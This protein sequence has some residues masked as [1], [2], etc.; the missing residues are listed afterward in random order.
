LGVKGLVVIENS[1]DPLHDGEHL[2]HFR[3][4]SECGWLGRLRDMSVE[5]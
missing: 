2:T 4:R 5:E 1:D 3:G